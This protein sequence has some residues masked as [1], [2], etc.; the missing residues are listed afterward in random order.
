MSTTGAEA[1]AAHPFLAGLR[2]DHLAALAGHAMPVRLPTGTRLFAEGGIAERFWLIRSGQVV[3]DVHLP[4][5]GTVLVETLGAGQVLGWSWLEP[6][7]RWHFGATARA[8]TDAFEFDADAVRELCEADP[9]LGY[10]LLRRFLP[11]VVDRLQASRI[12]LLD[13]YAA[14]AVQAAAEQP[15]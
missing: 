2:E 11:V 3:L 1:L 15:R 7:Y 6:P 14:D 10:A 13:L 5:R 8:A 9:A 4:G 12:R